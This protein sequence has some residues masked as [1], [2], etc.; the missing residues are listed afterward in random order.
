MLPIIYEF[1]WDCIV[2]FCNSEPSP[3]PAIATSDEEVNTPYQP[4]NRESAEALG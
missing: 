1:I 3:A 4:L 2:N